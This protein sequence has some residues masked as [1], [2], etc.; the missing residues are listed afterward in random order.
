MTRQLVLMLETGADDWPLDSHT[1]E[2]GRRGL[3]DARRAL[4]RASSRPAEP[5]SGRREIE[6]AKESRRGQAA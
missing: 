1:R 6:R 4:A 2:V 5:G 3:A